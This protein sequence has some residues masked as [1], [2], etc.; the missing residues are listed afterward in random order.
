MTIPQQIVKVGDESSRERLRGDRL[1]SVPV[2][3]DP[4]IDL[5]HNIVVRAGAGSGKTTILVDRM[6]ALVRSGVDPASIVAITFTNRAAAELRERFFVRLLEIQHVLSDRTEAMWVEEKIRVDHALQ[7]NDQAFIGTIHAFCLR[8]LR[9]RSMDAG[10]PPDFKQIEESDELTMRA[11]F[12]K[13]R[14]EEAHLAGDSNWGLLLKGDVSWS[15]LFKF[16]GLLSTNSSVQFDETGTERPDPGPAFA[17]VDS[18]LKALEPIV[19][20]S[21]DPDDFMMAVE[22]A[23]LGWGAAAR[24]D[25][26]QRVRILKVL[27]EGVRGSQDPSL[28]ITLNRWGQGRNSEGYKLAQRIKKGEDELLDGTS[29][30]DV[31]LGPIRDT[32]L[33]WDAWLHDAALRFAS[34]SVEAYRQYRVS[35]GLLTYDDLLHEARRLVFSSTSARRAFQERYSRLLVDEFQDTDPAQAA[36]LFGLC[37]RQPDRKDWS[38]SPLQPGKLFVVGDDK[39]SIYRFRKADFQVFEAVANAVLRDDGRQI[40]LTANFRT[41]EGLCGWINRS[42]GEILSSQNAPYQAQ[43][44][45]LVPAKGRFGPEHPVVH[46]A[47][48]KSGQKAQKPRVIA[49]A[50]AIARRIHASVSCGDSVFGDHMILFR[51]HTNIP[52]FLDMLSR[53]HIPVSLPGGK[54]KGAESVVRIVHDLMRVVLNP[55]DGVALIAV[56]RGILF[57][58]RDEDLMAYHRAGGRWERLFRD[59]SDA[60]GIPRS[61]LDAANVLSDWSDMF[62]DERPGSAFERFLAD[63]G[64]EGA[65]STEPNGE[66]LTGMLLRVGALFSSWDGQGMTIEACVR[67]LERYRNGELNLAPFST[68]EPYGAC[69]RVLTVHSSKGLQA[70]YVYLADCL[71]G[72]PHQTTLHVRRVD[73]ALRGSAPLIKGEGLF[74]SIELLPAGWATQHAEALRFEEAENIRLLYV[75]TTRAQRQLIISAHSATESTSGTWDIL[76]KYL[77]D[78]L[79]ERIDIDPAAAVLPDPIKPIKATEMSGPLSPEL[80][81]PFQLGK[82]TW[83]LQRPSE[84][85]EVVVRGTGSSDGMQYGSAVHTLFEAV[86][87]RRKEGM[88]D[89][90]VFAL[91]MEVM[92]YRF[93][94]ES[95]KEKAEAAADV[96]RAFLASDLWDR[97]QAADRVLTEVPLTTQSRE[98]DLSVI[99]SGVVDLAFRSGSHWTIV[100]YKTD[101]ASINELIERHAPQVGAYVR[102]WSSLFPKDSCEGL[103]WS[104]EHHTSIP[105]V[106]QE[107]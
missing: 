101:R 36:L 79:V 12:W 66:L 54:Q 38:L 92:R 97:L 68:K 26:F 52:I 49:E 14:I 16:F 37:S 99:T 93:R 33:A 100:D 1:L 77:L 19:P 50:A 74:G 53:L 20:S 13:K 64:L 82:P 95:A 63:S 90:D 25:D 31:I 106:I 9:Q 88:R 42:V 34:A 8:L 46:L 44:E 22:R 23:R 69:V 29:V 2:A 21:D 86:V 96:V 3:Q 76:G 103:I 107:T 4:S 61:I 28:G 55:A 43:W 89:A 60:E 10:L 58:I 81:E 56:L 47:I 75:A 84:G 70:P 65:L 39:Q 5:T 51:T 85:K 18:V 41:D 57:G 98:E 30:R 11:A 35:Q 7:N 27:L 72:R 17:L 83:L 40:K 87:A 73:G 62:R 71:P 6:I 78:P 24:A 102:A 67:E 94:S 32:V 105:V 80:V 91:T 48:G 104:T 15:G 45:P 59:R